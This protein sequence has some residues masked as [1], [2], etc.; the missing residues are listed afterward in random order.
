MAEH[1][2]E[3]HAVQEERPKG[4]RRAAAF[5]VVAV[6]I[7]TPAGGMSAIAT[8]GTSGTGEGQAKA[9]TAVSLVVSA[10]TATGQL[11]PGAAGDVRFRVQNP[12]TFPVT[13]TGWSGQSVASTDKS[14][15]GTGNFSV[16]A[17]SIAATPV[18]AG[19]AVTVTV[20]GGVS[21]N[22]DAPDACQGAGV[23]VSATV[24]A[25]QG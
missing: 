17:G 23:G 11:Y 15:C 3:R 18:A 10:G 12:N 19:A 22:S 1:G 25:A 24:T 8:W 5:V 2:D 13:V 9:T 6:A 4:R 21:M 16:N 14:G 20:V 7:A